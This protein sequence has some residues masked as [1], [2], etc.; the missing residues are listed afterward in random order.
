MERRLWTALLLAFLTQS[1]LAAGP[2]PRPKGGGYAQLS[3]T[4]IG[5]DKI[6]G[7]NSDVVDLRRR[8]TD[9]TIQ[10]YVEYGLT[11]RLTFSTNLPLKYV[12]SSGDVNPTDFFSDTLPSGDAVGLNSVMMGFKY[13][14]INKK[15]LFTAGLNGEANVALYDSVSTIRTGPRTFVI[16]P[17]LSAGTTFGKY[18]YT[19]LEAGYRVRLNGYSDDIDL[20]YELGYSWNQKTYFILAVRGRI[21]TLNGSYDNDVTT[22]NPFGRDIHTNIDPN[23]QQYIGYGLK[24]IQK[25]K[26]VHIN[27]G[28][29]SGYGQLV[30][31]AP[32][33][34]LGVAYEW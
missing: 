5:Y 28:V 8:M 33:F 32:S 11:D 17:Y 1:A 9:V 2:W 34:N 27:A 23:N 19:Q 30:A 7:P 18:F 13:N 29:Y 16:H 24:F 22:E 26:K 20:G 31:A 4:Y 15:V 14:I 10:A 21:S 25:I 6:F 3:A 12:A